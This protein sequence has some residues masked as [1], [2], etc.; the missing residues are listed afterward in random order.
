MKTS[1]GRT[2]LV[3]FVLVLGSS[4]MAQ[5]VTRNDGGRRCSNATLSGNYGA[6]IEGTLYIP[7]GPNPPIKVELRTISMGH[8]DGAGNVTFSDH[9]VVDGNPPPEEWRQ[10]S[11][12]Y[13]V[14]PDCTGSF[15]VFTAPAFPPIVVYFVVVKHGTQ[16][17]GVT[18][19]S[20]ITYGGYKV[21]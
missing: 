10:A 3:G 9:V 8:Y 13:S 14:N 16:I 5:S 17:H 21:N 6:Q 4:L 15:S 11:G 20:A 1:I 2:L 12:T 7:T 19:G 18:N